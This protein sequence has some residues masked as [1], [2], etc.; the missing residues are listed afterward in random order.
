[1]DA[2][3]KGLGRSLH[4]LRR[5]HHLSLKQVADASGMSASFLSLVENG[6]TDITVSRLQRLTRFY[7]VQLSD[8]VHE[9][10]STENAFIIRKHER[11]HIAFPSE[12]I[13]VYLLA[14]DSH[15][16]MVPVLSMFDPRAKAADFSEHPGEEFFIVLVGT[17]EFEF[18][19][20]EPIT[21]NAGD[22][23]YYRSDRPHLFLNAGAGQAQILF[24]S[25]PV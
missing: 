2:L 17:I 24:V 11:K 25:V 12:G 5:E 7:G 1:V 8:L 15:R 16:V 21:L 13:T 19:S 23:A 4:K 20:S 14:P 6:R 22:C 18:E 10:G 3:D 9:E